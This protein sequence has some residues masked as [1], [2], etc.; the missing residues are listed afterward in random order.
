MFNRD[1]KKSQPT[2]FENI[3]NS[4]SIF[5]EITRGLKSRFDLTKLSKE[6]ADYISVKVDGPYKP[7]AYRY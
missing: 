5:N 1:I 4:R 7:N 3:P 6:Q 2:I